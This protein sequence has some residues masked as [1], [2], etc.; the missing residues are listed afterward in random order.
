MKGKNFKAALPVILILACLA[1]L[2]FFIW[3]PGPRGSFF[4]SASLEASGPLSAVTSGLADFVEDL[5]R[6]YFNLVGV[7]EENAN[8]RR[9]LARQSQLSTQ[10]AE[11]RLENERLREL[12][13]FKAGSPESFTAVKVL[14]KDPTPY[15]RSIIIAAGTRDGLR[16]EA[17]V[18]TPEGAVGRI[19]ELSPDY[20]RVLLITDISSGA[21]ALIQRN[22]VNG[23]M[24]GTGTER[25]G[26]EYVQKG[27]DVRVG[28]TAVT[29]GLDGIFPPG[30]PLG[31][32]TFV[33]KMSMGFFMHAFVSPS[34]DFGSLEE[35]L[36]LTDGPEPLDWLGLAPSVRAL[37][38]KNSQN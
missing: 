24:A 29:S 14:A 33:D 11:A 10:L 22:R 20:A 1:F 6:N 16:P 25:L 38:E 32:I 21:D 37:Y 17:A 9:Q 8:F 12:V 13:D 30:I 4:G 26:L 31:P 28:D 3:S 2:S 19:I 34:V 5:W 23:L 15:F 27:E 36:V 7:R 18:I 35:V